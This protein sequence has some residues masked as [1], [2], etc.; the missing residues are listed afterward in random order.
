MKKRSVMLNLFQHLL[1]TVL[2]GAIICIG[3]SSCNNFM[4][5]GDV[6]AEIEEAIEIANS[7]AVTYYVFADENS[8]TVTPSQLQLKKKQ[9]FDVMYT[10]ATGWN[11]ICWEV[12]DRTTLEVITDSIE[13]KTPEKLETKASVKNLR[14]NCMI[15]PKAEQQPVIIAVSPGDSVI[16]FANTPIV[17][18][19]NKQMEAPDTL[20]F[21]SKFVYGSQNISI[22]YGQTDISSCF[23]APVFNSDKTELTIRPKYEE[24]VAFIS[25]R[26]SRYLEITVSFGDAIEVDF[27]DNLMTV[28]DKAFIAAKYKPDTEEEPPVKQE[29]FLT[30][31]KISLNEIANVSEDDKFSQDD[32]T[33]FG[34]PDKL[35]D[36]EI[37]R[38]TIQS[39]T[40]GTF[41]VYGKYTDS[42]S[43]VKTVRVKSYRLDR[44]E[45][46]NRY[47][48]ANENEEVFEFTK[49]SPNAVFYTEGNTTSF[50]VYVSVM[51]EKLE[52]HS[53]YNHNFRFIEVSVL[54]ACGNT[55]QETEDF[56]ACLKT[57]IEPE[58]YFNVSNVDYF[59]GDYWVN[60]DDEQLEGFGC[61]CFYLNE[62]E[63]YDDYWVLDTD[64]YNNNLK[65]LKIFSSYIAK[66]DEYNNW[67]LYEYN[68]FAE[69]PGLRGIYPPEL[70]TIEC[71][72]IGR[73]NTIHRE[74]FSEF[75]DD[76]KC[77]NLDLDVDSVDGLPFKIIITDDLGNTLEKE[78]SYPGEWPIRN[79]TDNGDGTSTIFFQ[80]DITEFIM[81][82]EDPQSGYTNVITPG[83]NNP[84]RD[85]ITIENGI[86]YTLVPLNGQYEPGAFMVDSS[87]MFG[88]IDR[89]Y[90][91][92]NLQ[93]ES[94]ATPVLDTTTP[95][96]LE[97]GSLNYYQ[98]DGAGST[99]LNCR[100]D[101]FGNCGSIDIT[102]NVTNGNIYDKLYLI[103][104]SDGDKYFY[105]EDGNTIKFSVR[106][107][108]MLSKET[109]FTVYGTKGIA[110]SEG[111]AVTIPQISSSDSSLDNTPPL[112]FFENYDLGFD[113]YV[114]RL[115]DDLSG[116]KRIDVYID[117]TFTYSFN[118][119]TCIKGNSTSEFF[120]DNGVFLQ[121]VPAE[122]INN[123]MAK[124]L[125]IDKTLYFFLP[126]SD[127]YGR[128]VEVKYWNTQTLMGYG[129]LKFF[130]QQ[131][132]YF[133]P[134][135][136]SLNGYKLTMK[137][138][139]IKGNQQ[140]GNK[141]SFSIFTFDNSKKVWIQKTRG[142]YNLD[143]EECE[144][145]NK[146]YSTNISVPLNQFIR[147]QS[148]AVSELSDSEGDPYEG[149]LIFTYDSPQYY[150]T[151]SK[152]NSGSKDYF[153]K[154]GY[155]EESMLVQSDAPAYIHTI[156]INK[157]L[158]D[159]QNWTEYEWELYGRSLGDQ[160]YEFELTAPEIYTIP[161]DQI[162]RGECYCMIAWF[163]DGSHIMSQ[164]KQKPY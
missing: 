87:F 115:N 22:L 27:S 158:S 9:S 81:F 78:F 96:T 39:R 74:F 137:T 33:C 138:K 136:N 117:S 72:Y 133:Y 102:V 97:Q 154:H 32:F 21:N 113:Y 38:K 148:S 28:N 49:D 29:L 59:N 12:L 98:G 144:N 120:K 111:V 35:Q 124:G 108:T 121:S 157:N 109:K 123:I 3:M 114:F 8:G 23:E 126:R 58:L 42:G 99:G 7:S 146:I 122:T 63:G 149:Q 1:I 16:S 20:S 164:I 67:D 125:L 10:P 94:V 57:G 106:Y 41:T 143:V 70:Y 134:V 36:E 101:F 52:T 61:N 85:K 156:A 13:F 17:I 73:D 69:I 37:A 118:A 110:A 91:T 150:Y 142:P 160:L 11:F 40:N 88:K 86:D 131:R 80:K 163:A 153:N 103:Y 155:S 54:D 77:W 84:Y 92:N 45:D 47:V 79:I 53:Y 26:T 147:I 65:N 66:P 19:F 159:I 60:L 18:T 151:G 15:H 83:S 24:L 4:K 30:N 5:A 82:F 71:E 46:L 105:S 56:Y 152:L 128:K 89:V 48:I 43:G 135:K 51:T 145:G 127:L 64:Y 107:K 25:A 93:V 139:E 62:P 140:V 50:C 100:F 104:H 55:T 2:G 6:R 132:G 31:K 44:N 112:L 116:P 119:D 95:Y 34:G 161:L 14:E 129:E 90:N 76:A 141:R 75:D 162:K 68:H 130:P